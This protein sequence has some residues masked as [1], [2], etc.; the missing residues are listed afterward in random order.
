MTAIQ[1]E[2]A[3]KRFGTVTAVDTD[4]TGAGWVTIDVALRAGDV[5]ASTCDVRVALPV[6]DNDNPWARRGDQWKP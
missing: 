1:I 5:V 3:S 6:D 4:D 2:R